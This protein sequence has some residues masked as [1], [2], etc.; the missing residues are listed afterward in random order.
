MSNIIILVKNLQDGETLH[1]SLK[2]FDETLGAIPCLTK[3]EVVKNPDATKHCEYIFSTWY[4]PEFT[5][6]EI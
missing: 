2:K 3:E 5:D 4:M 6:K 1:L